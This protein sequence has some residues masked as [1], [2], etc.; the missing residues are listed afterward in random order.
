M[1]IYRDILSLQFHK[2]SVVV[3]GKFDGIH[4]GHKFLLEKAI[5]V[6]RQNG[7]QVV[8]FTFMPTNAKQSVLMTSKERSAYLETIGI[9][10]L[11][12]CSFEAVRDIEAI[13]FLEKIL[14][15]QLQMR[16]LIAGTDCGFGK[17]RTGNAKMAVEFMENKG[18]KAY[19]YDKLEYDGKPI[20]ST[21]VRNMVC[22]GQMELAEKLLGHPY[23]FE[24]VVVKG[25]QLGRTMNFP[26][27]NLI[28]PDSKVVPPFGVYESVVSIDDED[29]IG[30]T[31]IG[32]K[33][34][35]G[36]NFIGVETY[37]FDY[38]KDAYEKV[39]KVSLKKFIRKE[40]KFANLTMLQEQIKKDID[41]IK[42]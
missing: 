42:K 22:E 2:P 13:D 20:S 26:T 6:S 17:N 37:I 19:I 1:E 35:V 15:K 31:N 28:I 12:E 3:I 27:M 18:Q 29:Y 34:T 7:W 30:I 5:E 11:I 39:I 8:V 14:W 40:M 21:F 25:N 16:C 36:A 9:D 41:F 38:S 32:V 33:P 4:K 24:G 23:Y 10:V